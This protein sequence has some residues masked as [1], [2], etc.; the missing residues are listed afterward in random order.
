V[1]ALALLAACAAG[2]FYGLPSQ[3]VVPM[4]AASLL[5]L[6]ASN[7]LDRVDLEQGSKAKR[8][9]GVALAI[10]ALNS[11]AVSSFAFFTGALLQLMW[12]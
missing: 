12:Q 2:G 5:A 9:A 10:F 1:P 8:V 3:I 6:S 11:L 4:A 7:I